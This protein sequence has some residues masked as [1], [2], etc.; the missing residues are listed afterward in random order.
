MGGAIITITGDTE[1]EVERKLETKKL[2][3]LNLGLYEELRT[4]TEFDQGK[5]QYR[6]IL[7]VHS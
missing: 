1:K 2:E 5:Q 3:A 7:K 6:A 4:P